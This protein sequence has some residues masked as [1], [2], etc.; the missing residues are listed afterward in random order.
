MRDALTTKQIKRV[1]SP[2]VQT[3]SNTALVGQI[4]DHQGFDAATYILLTGA[5][6]DAT[7]TFAVL[8]EESDNSDMSSAND[9]ADGDMVSQTR[10]TAAET[11]AAF[12]FADDNEVRSLGYIG[13]K[14]YTRL[15]VTPAT[16]DDGD[17]NLAAVC[18]LELA[19]HQPVEKAAA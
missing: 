7:A 2:A 5:L 10:G 18:I 12:T 8:L 6:T 11:A 19:A 3:D 16:N 4:I 9:V 14:R 17:I 15:T 13:S 1:L